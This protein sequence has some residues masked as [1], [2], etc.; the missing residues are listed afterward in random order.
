MSLEALVLQHSILINF[1]IHFLITTLV[2]IVVSTSLICL[3]V[4]LLYQHLR[5]D[6]RL[7]KSG[8]IS[9]LN[10]HASCPFSNFGQ[11]YYSTIQLLAKF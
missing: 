5:D 7:D 9:S 1:L 3:I 4:G 11:V 6:S 8:H 2:T 10:C